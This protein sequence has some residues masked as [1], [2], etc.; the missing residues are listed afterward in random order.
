MRKEKSIESICLV[1]FSFLSLIQRWRK[2]LQAAAS[3]GQQGEKPTPS[4]SNLQRPLEPD[5]LRPP[6]GIN[7]DQDD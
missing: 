7:A 2:M 3:S 4:S 1:A 6:P 5:L